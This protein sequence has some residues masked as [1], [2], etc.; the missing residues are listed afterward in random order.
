MV[1]T[2]VFAL[3]REDLAA[4]HEAPALEAAR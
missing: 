3:K 1:E 2:D 4:R